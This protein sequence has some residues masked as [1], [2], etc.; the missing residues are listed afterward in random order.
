M[1]FGT[2]LVCLDSLI[3]ILAHSSCGIV[4][5]L[6]TTNIHYTQY[7]RSHFLHHKGW[8]LWTVREFFLFFF[9][10]LPSSFFFIYDL[11]V[12]ILYFKG[13]IVHKVS[14]FHTFVFYGQPFFSF[15]VCVSSYSLGL[16]L[17]LTT[18][19]STST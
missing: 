6:S 8:S 17:R 2:Q 13:C 1:L 5:K 14:C 19:V 10:Y 16:C 18:E 15:F 3:Q 9:I 12:H 7:G 11:K 4:L